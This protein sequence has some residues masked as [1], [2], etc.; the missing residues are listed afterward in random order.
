[1][2]KID[3]SKFAVEP[4]EPLIRQVFYKDQDLRLIFFLINNHQ[5][6]T[7][8]ELTRQYNKLFSSNYQRTWIYQKL[9]KIE[10]Y[11]MLDKRAVWECKA[12][13]VAIE[14]QILETHA[15]WLIGKSKSFEK[16][17][18][19]NEYIYLTTKGNEW[20]KKVEELQQRVSGG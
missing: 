3:L 7:L 4:T 10:N 18:Q 17:F 13:G 11:G 8:S 5:P 1:M 12:D 6:L 2:K 15:K 14:V 19:S 9:L 16:R 20:V